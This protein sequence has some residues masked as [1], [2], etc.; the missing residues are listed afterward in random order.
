MCA[1][2][3]A[4]VVLVGCEKSADKT[5]ALTLRTSLG[6]IELELYPDKAPLTVANFMRYVDDELYDGA[7]FYRTVRADNQA[8]NNVRIAVIQGGLGLPDTPGALSP[9][10]HES[11]RQTGLQHVDGTLSLA[12]DTPG[13]GTSEFFICVGPQAQLDYGGQR[14]P[15]GV[16]FAAFGKVVAGM[17]VVRAIHAATTEPAGPGELEYTSG[18]MLDPEIRIV[19]VSVSLTP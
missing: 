13:S 11:T 19:D 7:T 15:D 17:D 12:R 4:L 3:V 1:F 10:A 9:I 8:Q 16:G 2:A 14:H 5:I 6:D 18:Q